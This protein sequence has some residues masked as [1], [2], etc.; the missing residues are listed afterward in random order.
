MSNEIEYTP[1][2]LLDDLEPQIDED[3]FLELA[4]ADERVWASLNMDHLRHD[5]TPDDYLEGYFGHRGGGKS[6]LLARGLSIRLGAND[7]VFTN[8]TMFPEK[9]GIKNK[10]HPLDFTQIT[11]FD[12]ALRA[13]TI[14]IEEI[15]TWIEKMRPTSTSNILAL[16]WIR[17]KIRKRNLIVS[18]TTQSP[19][20]PSS[21][22]EQLDKMLLCRDMFFTPWGIE[23]AIRK[24][25]T[26][27]YYTVDI[28]GLF[29]GIPGNQWSWGLR[30]ADRIWEVF[31]SYQEF[32]PFEW[33]KKIKVVGEE[34]VIDLDEQ[35]VYGATEAP[36]RRAQND[37]ENYGI[38]LRHV[39]R[40][41]DPDLLKAAR[42]KKAVVKETERSIVLSIAKTKQMIDGLEKRKDKERIERQFAEL[43]QLAAIGKVAKFINGNTQIVLVKADN[44]LTAADKISEDSEVET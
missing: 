24:G 17:Q 27:E 14:G 13:A 23:N 42:S 39:W 1:I 18:M 36:M 10:P 32:D 3:Q 41:W 25:T 8:L 44:V 40:S 6:T 19:K 21:I 30:R 5:W 34:T 16:K 29:T 43:A 35:A 12:T 15:D 31:D 37:L 28:S 9:L 11:S 38:L 22:F 20:L 4:A 26:F 7:T 2:A 33:T